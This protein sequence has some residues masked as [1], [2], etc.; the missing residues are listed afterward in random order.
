MEANL[1]F[2]IYLNF[3]LHNWHDIYAFCI[4]VHDNQLDKTEGYWGTIVIPKIKKTTIDT[5]VRIV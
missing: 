1:S 3:I 4:R 5:N 2:V